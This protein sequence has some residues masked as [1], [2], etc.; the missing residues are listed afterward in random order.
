MH[1]ARRDLLKMGGSVGLLALTA[2][3]GLLRAGRAWAATVWNPNAFSSKT[4]DE[5]VKALGG[6]RASD[7]SDIALTIPEI[8]ENGAVVPVVIES[9]LANTRSIAILVEKNPSALSAVFDIPEGTD[10][11]IG[12]RI[13]IGS[14]SNVYALVKTESGYYITSKQVKVTL[15]GCGG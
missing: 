1:L 7:S 13:K 15:G 9:K 14:T 10:A 4:V 6:T 12:A 8:A 11:Y 5:V 3:T 2:G